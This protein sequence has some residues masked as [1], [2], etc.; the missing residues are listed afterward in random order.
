MVTKHNKYVFKA[1][2]DFILINMCSK[3]FIKIRTKYTGERA[4]HKLI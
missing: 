2:I 3:E 4:S 1:D